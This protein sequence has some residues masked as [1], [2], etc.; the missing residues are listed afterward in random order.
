MTEQTPPVPYREAKTAELQEKLKEAQAKVAKIEAQ[1][2]AFEA[3]AANEEAINNLS[4]GDTVAY[5]YGRAANKRVLSG[6]VRYVGKTDKGAVQLKVETGEGLDAEFNLI[7]STAL[8]LTQE[9][10]V[11]AQAAIDAEK[12]KTPPPSDGAK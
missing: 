10:V 4:S 7:D 9:Q 5:V 3:D 8:L 6:V 12:A 2:A 1:I 11:A